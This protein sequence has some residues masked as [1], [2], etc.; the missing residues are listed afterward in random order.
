MEI[1]KNELNES[2]RLLKNFIDDDS[3]INAIES[4]A[5]LMKVSI[6]NGGLVI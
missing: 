1:I 5:E 3:N 6:K 2:Y 4:A